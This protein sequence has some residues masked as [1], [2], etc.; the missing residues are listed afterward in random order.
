MGAARVVRAKV[1]GSVLYML[2]P[3]RTI[4]DRNK[5]PMLNKWPNEMSERTT[6]Y[7]SQPL[8]SKCHTRHFLQN[9]Q[10]LPFV[11][12]S[13][14]RRNFADFLRVYDRSLPEHCY[15]RLALHWKYDVLRCK[16]FGELDIRVNQLTKVHN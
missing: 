5:Y 3:S 9:F 15:V 14:N 12:S 4:S 7:A 16:G 6:K 13:K 8:V 10:I 2:N 1:G 11:A